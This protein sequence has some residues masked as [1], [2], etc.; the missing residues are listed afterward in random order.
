MI[1]GEGGKG[2]EDKNEENKIITSKIVKNR[3]HSGILRV[4]NDV[5]SKQNTWVILLWLVL[6]VVIL[7]Q[8]RQLHAMRTEVNALKEGIDAKFMMITNG[9]NS[10]QSNVVYE[11]ND[12]VGS[13]LTQTMSEVDSYDIRYLDV[14]FAN[15]M[16][17]VEITLNLKSYEK[18]ANYQATILN[19]S[20][21]STTTK[22]FEGDYLIRKCTLVLSDETNYTMSF[23]KETLSGGTKLTSGSIDLFIRDKISNRTTVKENSSFRNESSAILQFVINNNTFQNDSASIEKV[24]AVLSYLEEE[25]LTIQLS[26]VPLD[27][28][29]ADLSG[30]QG[31]S[32][33]SVTSSSTVSSNSTNTGVWTTSPV[34]SGE[35]DEAEDIQNI[36]EY[37]QRRFQLDVTMDTIRNSLS[38]E[39]REKIKF[40]D[41]NINMVITYKDGTKTTLNDISRFIDL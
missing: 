24:E 5:C 9:I 17:T 23:E 27:Y 3:I 8:G 12:E 29:Y 11:V 14:D 34:E 25:F 15:H 28:N 41:I 6:V 13:L 26:E 1:R 20:D 19:L 31:M 10:L 22:V 30:D 21:S 7:Y 37:E 39:H 33:S 36:S 16:V 18:D 4:R 38:S 2:L 32:S 40:A 35:I